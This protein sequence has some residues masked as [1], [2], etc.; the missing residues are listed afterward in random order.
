MSGGFAVKLLPGTEQRWEV[1]AS[2]PPSVSK[3]EPFLIT[4]L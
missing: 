3:Q 1:W 2:W 4:A